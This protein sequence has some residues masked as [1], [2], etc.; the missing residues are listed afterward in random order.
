MYLPCIN[1]GNL[2]MLLKNEWSPFQN[3]WNRVRV[4]VRPRNTGRL[5]ST[6]F[7]RRWKAETLGSSHSELAV[8]NELYE[9][10]GFTHDRYD[11]IDDNNNNNNKLFDIRRCNDGHFPTLKQ[12]LVRTFMIEL[13][14]SASVA[15]SKIRIYSPNFCS[16]LIEIV[17]GKMT[18]LWN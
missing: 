13:N 11:N 9:T 15:L 17:N 18:L 1:P 6:L 4:E 14:L 16:K 7:V 2:Y 12:V 3:I 5:F 8:S 10:T